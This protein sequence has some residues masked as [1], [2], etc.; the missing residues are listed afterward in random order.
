MSTLSFTRRRRRGVGGGRRGGV[1]WAGRLGIAAIVAYCLAPFYW[2][3][4][5]SLRR[6]ADQFSNA[7]LPAPASFDNY[8][9]PSTRT[10]ASAGRSSTASSSQ[11]YT[12]EPPWSSA[13]SPDTPWRGCSSAARH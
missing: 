5:S 13:S 3:V 12:P 1:A 6:P 2:M 10:T 8:T 7:P 9:P 11:E 4:V